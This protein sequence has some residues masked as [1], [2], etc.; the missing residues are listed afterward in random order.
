MSRGRRK[1][2]SGKKVI[3]KEVCGDIATGRFT[4]TLYGGE[5]AKELKVDQTIQAKKGTRGSAK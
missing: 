1:A 2:V 4:Q 3:F 5:A